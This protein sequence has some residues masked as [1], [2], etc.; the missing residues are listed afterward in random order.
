MKK[1]LPLM[2]NTIIFTSLTTSSVIANCDT[3]QSTITVDSG[4]YCSIDSTIT[5]INKINLSGTNSTLELKA[6]FF[7]INGNGGTSAH[8]I[9]ISGSGNKLITNNLTI[10]VSNAT[11]SRGIY[12]TG[13]SNEIITTGL[14]INDYSTY[15]SP[16]E[17]IG[18]SN[19]VTVNGDAVL[20][21]RNSDGY[22]NSGVFNVSGDLTINAGTN[23]TLPSIDGYGLRQ[24]NSS[25]TAIEGTTDI[26]TSLGFNIWNAGITRLNGDVLLKK[27]GVGGSI[28]NYSDFYAKNII[29]IKNINGD[30]FLNTGKLK[31]DAI[32]DADIKGNTSSLLKNSAGI[33]NISEINNSKSEGYLFKINGGTTEVENVKNTFSQNSVINLSE[34]SSSLLNINNSTLE[35]KDSSLIIIGRTAN[36]EDKST[37]NIS[38]SELKFNDVLVETLS[39]NTGIANINFNNISTSGNENKIANILSG[40]VN[41]NFKNQSKIIGLTDYNEDAILNIDLINSTV[42][43]VT[44]DSKLTNLN[45]NDSKVFIDKKPGNDFTTLTINK[46]YNGQGNSLLSLNTAL[47]DDQ[48][49][50]DLVI[51]GGQALGSTELKI[52]NAGGSGAQTLKGIKIIQT[53]SSDK[54][55]FFIANGGFVTA[56]A[57]DYGLFL[58]AEEKDPNTSEINDN[59]YLK[60]HLKD[61]PIYTHTPDVGSYLAT[62]TMGNTLFTSRLEDREGASQYQNLGNNDTGN[63]WVRAFGGHNKFKTMDSQLKTTGN[64]FV[65]QIGVGLLTLGEEDQ[66]NVGAMTGFAYYDGKTRSSLTDRESKTKIDGYSLGLYGTWYAHPVEKRGAYIDSWVLWNKF[67]N[68]IDTPDQNQ[69]KYDSSGVTASI[70]V[71][72]DYLINKN[73]KN[74]WWIQPQSQV[75]YQGVHAD[76]FKD[77]QGLN[78]NHGRDNVQARMGVKTYLEIPTNNNKLTSYRPYVALNFIHNTNPYSVV[79][80]D[81]RYENEGS[82]NLGELKLG[83]EG[84]VTQN[85]QVWL[86]ASYFAGSHS[87]QSYQGNIGWKYNF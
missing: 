80:D 41:L 48:S 84:N 44:D 72:G 6:D 77:A 2:I 40:I 11:N 61:T 87:N 21:T 83:V 4:T 38:N 79:I 43:N 18:S 46:N 55:A 12:Y 73:G 85:S 78:I 66:Y 62:E 20:N 67:N 7:T 25:T 23:Q 76:D 86:N 13:N 32:S 19:I 9:D 45:N 30:V 1:N 3:S 64:S 5:A 75:I 59:W 52:V 36:N 47:G 42:W 57:Y 37:V 82:A 49:L 58:N 51:I 65:T 27:T 8:D 15:G 63:I 34:T 22:R 35:S 39:N 28:V 81:V 71:G 53:K 70:E 74:N 31:I 60:S 68:K 50:S 54:N 69:Y 17:N 24:Y 14:T 16:I 56:G 26:T 29:S 33:T 10:N